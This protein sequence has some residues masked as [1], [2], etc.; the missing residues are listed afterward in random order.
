MARLLD[1]ARSQTET[2]GFGFGTRVLATVVSLPPW[3]F[4]PSMNDA[5][6]AAASSMCWMRMRSAAFILRESGRNDISAKISAEILG[7]PHVH[8]A[9]KDFGQLH[10]HSG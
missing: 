4:R 8:L 1:S 9:A 10:F 3:W 6:S 2:I 5:A 7:S